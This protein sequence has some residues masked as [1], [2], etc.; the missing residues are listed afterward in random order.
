MNKYLGFFNCTNCGGC[1]VTEISE[2][3]IKFEISTDKILSKHKLKLYY[4]NKGIYFNWGRRIYL[5]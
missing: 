5:E 4:N 2:E 3:F 1:G